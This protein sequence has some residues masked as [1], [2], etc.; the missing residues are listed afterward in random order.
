MIRD[1]TKAGKLE[2]K[3]EVRLGGYIARSDTLSQQIIDAFEELEAAKVEHSSF[4]TLQMTEKAAIPRRIQSLEDE[5][6]R[7]SQMERDLQQKY[8]TLSEEKA[9]YMEGL[10]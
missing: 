2:K 3:L 5:V 8:K 1:A 6:H 9:Y 7:L 10:V 4:L